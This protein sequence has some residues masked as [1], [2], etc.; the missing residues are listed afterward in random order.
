MCSIDHIFTSSTII[1]IFIFTFYTIMCSL[2]LLPQVHIPSAYFPSS[3][4]IILPS[5][6]TAHTANL[7]LHQLFTNLL[8]N[9]HVLIFHFLTYLLQLHSHHLIY[10][11]LYYHLIYLQYFPPIEF[12]S[13]SP[14]V[15]KS[16]LQSF[17]EN[18][19]LIYY[20]IDCV[21]FS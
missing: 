20:Q 6:T 3:A 5:P 14:K 7:Y 8:Q 11:H 9:N 2:S 19:L 13:P 18:H 4:S 10:F 16:Q 17:S 21:N 15:H 12:H 1:S